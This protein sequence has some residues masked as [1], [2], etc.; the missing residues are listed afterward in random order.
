[1]KRFLKLHFNMIDDLRRAEENAEK[2][3][4][5]VT[6]GNLKWYADELA[7]YK[8]ER[9]YFCDITRLGWSHLK[10]WQKHVIEIAER[11][12]HCIFTKQEIEDF[13]ARLNEYAHNQKNCSGNVSGPNF[14]DE[15]KY[16]IRP[17]IRVGSDC[18]P[19]AFTRIKGD[20]E[21]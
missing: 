9:R 14:D 13:A 2:A 17:I 20:Y 15:E 3:G 7:N 4:F 5:G 6:A 18:S 10:A 21:Y 1:M 19:I 12:N 16:K 8:P 11:Y